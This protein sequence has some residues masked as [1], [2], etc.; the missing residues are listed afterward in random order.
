MRSMHIR[1]Q[2]NHFMHHGRHQG[3]LNPVAAMWLPWKISS[4]W[5]LSLISVVYGSALVIITLM[6]LSGLIWAQYDARWSPS[7]RAPLDKVGGNYLGPA[8][9]SRQGHFF[10]WCRA[11]WTKQQGFSSAYIFRTPWLSPPSSSCSLFHF[12]LHST[13]NSRSLFPHAC[14]HL[15]ACVLHICKK[16]GSLSPV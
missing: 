7:S 12:H 2:G 5:G 6:Y 8:W 11:D 1:T 16:E 4:G 15:S 10:F 14:V 9:L 13:Y 3:H